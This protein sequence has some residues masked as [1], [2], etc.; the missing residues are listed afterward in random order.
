[1]HWIKKLT[2]F[3]LTLEL[4]F[5]CY[6]LLYG[7]TLYNISQDAMAEM[8]VPEK[9]REVIAKVNYLID[10]FPLKHFIIR[11]RPFWT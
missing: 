10:I 8:E 4:D 1:M 9:D 7:I 6:L 3:I 2:Y 11:L 5:S